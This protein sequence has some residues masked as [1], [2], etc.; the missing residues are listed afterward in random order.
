MFDGHDLD[1]AEQLVDDWQARISERA[2]AARELSAR[3]AEL[4]GT[5]RSEDGLV[6]VTVGPA[7][8]VTALELDEGIRRRPAATTAQAI[9]ATMRAA[10]AA[11][12]AAATAVTDE[13]VGAD[14]P[15]GRA[16]I[17]SYTARQERADD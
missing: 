4:T 2:A 12:T 14:T 7:G 9:L 13:T 11:L 6:E 3:L 1:A 10:Q 15:T 17:A 16:V 8:T 5:A